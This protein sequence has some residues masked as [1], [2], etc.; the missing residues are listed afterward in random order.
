[1]S[2]HAGSIWIDLNFPNVPQDIWVAANANRLVAENRD[3]VRLMSFLAAQRLLLSDLTITYI[4]SG[5]F[6]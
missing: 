6:Q 5:T 3:L 2:V 1:M 4:P